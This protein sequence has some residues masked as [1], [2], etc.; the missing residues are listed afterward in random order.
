MSLRRWLIALALL[1][2]ATDVR[3]AIPPIRFHAAPE[4]RGVANRLSATPPQKIDD[5]MRF[6]GARDEQP[7][8][9][10][11]APNNSSYAAAVPRWA[12]GYAL[13]D[14]STIVIFPQRNPLYPDDSLEETYLHEL[15][16]LFVHRAAGGRNVPRWFNEGVAVVAGRS[17]SLQDQARFS[18]LSIRGERADAATLDAM[19]VGDAS[20]ASRAY[21]VAEAFVRDV[22]REH[23]AESVRVILGEVARGESFSTAFFDSTTYTPDRALELFWE[24]QGWR[25][26]IVPA[27]SSSALLWLIITSIAIAAIRRRRRRDALQREAWQAEEELEDLEYLVDDDEPV[28]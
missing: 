14:T 19:F 6:I 27:I 12:A 24:T 25:R 21:V 22:L 9:V 11:L 2:L 20:D 8:D 23:G 18:Y 28:N 5:V 13:S 3:A 10:I 4:F 15:A 17:W 7:I 1:M 16:H 26:G